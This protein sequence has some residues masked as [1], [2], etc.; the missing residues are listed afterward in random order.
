MGDQLAG[1]V[2]VVTGGGR[3]I[4]KAIAIAYASEG[5]DIC[6]VART[7]EQI[8]EVASEIQTIGRKVLAVP[9]DVTNRD[10]VE[11][12]ASRVREDFGKIDILVNNAGGGIERN[13]VLESDPEL[14]IKD[15]NTNLISVYLMTHALLPLMIE[16]GGG[17]IISTGSGM[18]HISGPKGSAYHVG[19]AGLWM[20]T[21]CLAEEVWEH[22]INVNE[23]VPG[24]VASRDPSRV[25]STSAFAPA[26]RVKATE[27]VVPVAMFLAT[28]PSTGPTAQSFSIAR[29]PIE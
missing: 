9:T 7:A 25:G 26:E 27:D 13:L 8:D 24:P 28:Q 18:G 1:K 16:S 29:R 15:V 22:G 21:K 17:H 19:K 2:A 12:T 11:T 3:G 14:W 23:L 10:Q 4:G 20:F 5:A 6:L